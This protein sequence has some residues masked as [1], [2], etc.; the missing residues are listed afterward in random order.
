MKL[1]WGHGTPG[2]LPENT[3]QGLVFKKIESQSW[4]GGSPTGC[5]KLPWDPL[6]RQRPQPRTC[7]QQLQTP[8][9]LS[10]VT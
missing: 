1:K 4:G 7:P 6:L 2:C 3:L 5:R 10:P 9:L 8:G